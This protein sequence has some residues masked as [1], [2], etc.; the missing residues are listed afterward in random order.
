[1]AIALVEQGSKYL[2]SP[3]YE[4]QQSSIAALAVW[5]FSSYVDLN[6]GCYGR[7]GRGASLYRHWSQL[8]ERLWVR[9]PLPIGQFSEI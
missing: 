4:S 7:F 6:I 8:F 2:Y 5:L 3:P 9:L 1:M